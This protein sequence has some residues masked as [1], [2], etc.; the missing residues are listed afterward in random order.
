MSQQLRIAGMRNDR[1]RLEGGL[2]DALVV[3]ATTNA[4]VERFGDVFELRRGRVDVEPDGSYHEVGLR[5]FG[6]GI[7]HKSPSS[8]AEIGSKRVYSI[9]PN[10]LV[11]SNVFGWEGALAVASSDEEG[12]IGS[13]RFMTWVSA[14][15]VVV[16]PRWAALY[17]TRG[18]GLAGLGRASPG[19]A[20]RNGTLA[21][22]RL[23]NVPI[24]VP[25]A[26]TQAQVVQAVDRIRGL[27]ALA[28]RSE[29]LLSALIPAA[30][31]AAFRN[32]R[33]NR[34]PLVPGD[35]HMP[36]ESEPNRARRHGET[37]RGC[38]VGIAGLAGT[39][40]SA[41]A[42]RG[43]RMGRRI[44]YATERRDQPPGLDVVNSDGSGTQRLKSSPTRATRISWSPRRRHDRLH[45]SSEK[46]P[47]PERLGAA[48]GSPSR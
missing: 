37:L 43:P 28:D 1:Q 17:L 48:Q 14:H 44:V 34:L 20:G 7:F 4:R 36:K 2:A 23:Q 10:D 12:T 3:R 11:I 25:S 5:S 8:G 21:V 31:N 45:D 30:L 47:H 26:D 46:P 13:H 9:C 40:G 15:E 33:R 27:D 6:G 24:R 32:H 42:R 39:A 16:D 35:D 18:E 29:T 41:S 19:S 22:S 38:K